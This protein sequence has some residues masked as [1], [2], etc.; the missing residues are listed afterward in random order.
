[1]YSTERVSPWVP[2]ARPS[3]LSEDNVLICWINAL[4]SI[5]GKSAAIQIMPKRKKK[6]TD[7]FMTIAPV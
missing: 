4:S 2:G 6:V 3:N 5:F 1:M 7:L